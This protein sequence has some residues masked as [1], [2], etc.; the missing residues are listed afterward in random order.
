MVSRLEDSRVRIRFAGGTADLSVTDLTC[1]ERAERPSEWR[2]VDVTP[3]PGLK[4]PFCSVCS[5]VFYIYIKY[6]HRYARHLNTCADVQWQHL[7]AAWHV[8]DTSSLRCSVYV[9]RMRKRK[10]KEELSSFYS[11]WSQV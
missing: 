1:I 10:E 11:T 3:S 5:P 9:K 8:F 4:Y 6:L 7:D 2:V